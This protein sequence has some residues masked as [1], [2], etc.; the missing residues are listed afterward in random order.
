[1]NTV[2]SAHKWEHGWEL[3]LDGIP[4]TQV[5]TLDKAEQQVR[6]Y[7]DTVEPEVDHGA[8]DI[9]IVPNIGILYDEVVAARAATE[10]ASAA[11]IEAAARA[12]AA[13]KHLREAGFSV[14]DSAA[15]LRVS[16]GRV[17]QL[18]ARA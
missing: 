8:W 11:T 4:V 17:S 2:A 5:V 6:D 9:T 15:I 13:A 3:H 12:S 7:L 1:M 18:V 16:R 10:Q 14:A